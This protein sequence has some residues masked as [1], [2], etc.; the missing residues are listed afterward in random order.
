MY[1][2]IRFHRQ[3]IHGKCKNPPISLFSPLPF[4]RCI[5]FLDRFPPFTHHT[6]SSSTDPSKAKNPH[7]PFPPCPLPT[8]HITLYSTVPRAIRSCSPH[9]ITSTITTYSDLRKSETRETGLGG[10]NTELLMGEE[11]SIDWLELHIRVC[12]VL[13]DFRSWQKLME[14]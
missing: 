7:S 5:H 2:Q 14:G 13:V 9:T 3:G 11:G 1:P 4:P 6:R 12:C 8:L 10:R